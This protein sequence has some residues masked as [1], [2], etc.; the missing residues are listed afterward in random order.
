MLINWL[1]HYLINLNGLLMLQKKLSQIKL[2]VLDVDGVLTDGRI[3]YLESG[4]EIKEFNVKDGFGI[5]LLMDA[6]ITVGIISGRN[7]S[8]LIKRC[9]ELG[10]NL[11]YHGVKNK[12][13]AL[14]DILNIT[15]IP[16]NHT[17][18]MGD[19][20]PDI[21][22]MSI[23]CLSIAVADA[24]SDVL[25]RADMTTALKGGKGAVRE[26]CE[27]ILKAKGLWEKTTAPYL[28]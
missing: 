16:L 13:Q 15:S 7:S 22:V 9:K 23:V 12:I 26:V 1:A 25:A 14:E 28:S 11:V 6:G 3:I 19:D 10:I 18:F 17:A 20:I 8:A 24:S 21:P 2:L 4:E 27:E 5:R